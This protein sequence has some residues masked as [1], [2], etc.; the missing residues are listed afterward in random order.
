MVQKGFLTP[1]K[2]SGGTTLKRPS[3]NTGY[4]L[5]HL[6][7]EFLAGYALK[8]MKKSGVAQNRKVAVTL[9]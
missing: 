2:P 1:D 4:M 8:A 6:R 9:P 7:A 3:E 5:I